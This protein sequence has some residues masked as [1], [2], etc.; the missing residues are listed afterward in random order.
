MIRKENFIVNKNQ[1][2]Q[3]TNS[4]GAYFMWVFT[5]WIAFPLGS[6]TTTEVTKIKK[7]VKLVNITRIWAKQHGIHKWLYSNN[8]KCNESKWMQ[9]KQKK[10]KKYGKKLTRK[11]NAFLNISFATATRKTKGAHFSFVQ[12]DLLH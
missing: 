4:T 5:N 7:T 12:N 9:E 10:T 6:Q 1:P 8:G 11:R 3:F 2:H